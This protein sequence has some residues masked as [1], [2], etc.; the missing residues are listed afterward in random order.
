MRERYK[1]FW[2]ISL[3]MLIIQL[4]SCLGEP[5]YDSLLRTSSQWRATFYL[6]DHVPQFQ[7]DLKREDVKRLQA[8]F[9]ANKLTK[10]K[11]AGGDVFSGL[12][13]K[14]EA[15]D[16]IPIAPRIVK[17]D[18][19]FTNDVIHVTHPNLLRHKGSSYFAG[20]RL[21]P[22]LASDSSTLEAARRLGIKAAWAH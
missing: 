15:Y 13:V 5:D 17:W 18:G 20:T 11:Y 1:V 8:N 16:G 9:S 19:A 4:E 7:F 14:L 3:G 10:I 22:I 6:G 21:F 12:Y 2:A